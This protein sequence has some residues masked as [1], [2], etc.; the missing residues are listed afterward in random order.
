MNV[1]SL[2]LCEELY[3]L[4]RWRDTAFCWFNGAPIWRHVLSPDIDYSHLIPAY[5]IEYLLR[6]IGHYNISNN[7]MIITI[8]YD[9]GDV[10][11]EIE[12][13][14]VTNAA[15]KLAIELIKRGAF[16]P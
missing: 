12:D 7:G 10:F 3:K 6:K 13:A 8:N 11:C 4:A 16:Q 5:D 14:D 1:A 15:C 2:K 9:D